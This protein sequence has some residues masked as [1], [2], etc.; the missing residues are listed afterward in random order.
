MANIIVLEKGRDILNEILEISK[1]VPHS[2]CSAKRSSDLVE[3]G[4]EAKTDLL[5]YYKNDGVPVD[6][7]FNRI[8]EFRSPPKVLVVVDKP[9]FSELEFSLREGA[10]DYIPRNEATGFL[11]SL[12]GRLDQLVVK[13][14]PIGAELGERFNIVGE[15]TLM[16]NCLNTVAKARHSDVSVLIQG[17]TGTGKE[18]IARAIHGISTR[19]SKSLIVVDCASLPDTLV[20][21]ILFGYSKGAFTGADMQNEGLVMRAHGGTLFL[22]EVSELPLE[23]QKKFLRVLQERRFRPVGAKREVESDFRL[24]A[25]TNKDL[26]QMVKDGLFRSDLLYRIQSLKVNLPPLRSRL[27]DLPLLIKHLLKKSCK[28]NRISEKSF[29]DCF[30]ETMKC[31]DWPGNV[32]ELENVLDSVVVLAH[33]SPVVYPEHIPHYI[34][35]RVAKHSLHNNDMQSS[36][37]LK[38]I[39]GGLVTRSSLPTYKKYRNEVLESMEQHYF[40][41]VYELSGG[42]LAEAMKITNLSRARLYEFYKRYNLTKSEAH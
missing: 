18:L 10:L 17:E 40:K 14:E 1:G 8:R 13:D 11:T 7:L 4:Q 5:V 39:T 37:D 35:V 25:A 32:R 30:L 22:D 3:D 23:L 6:Q 34:R 16:R 41:E 31:H 26:S 12:L 27:E 2:V 20:E 36:G 42:N 15:C 29:S 33:F 19:S 28:K 9:D 24:V 38:R 21:S